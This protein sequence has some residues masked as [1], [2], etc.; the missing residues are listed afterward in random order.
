MAADIAQDT[1]TQLADQPLEGPHV[2]DAL[3][4][5]VAPGTGDG[6][7]VRTVEPRQ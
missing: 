5:L 2:D 4:V 3:L 7:S 6:I 1:T